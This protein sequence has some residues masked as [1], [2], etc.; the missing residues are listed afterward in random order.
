MPLPSVGTTAGKCSCYV[1]NLHA[2]RVVSIAVI[3]A[4]INEEYYG[5]VQVHARMDEAELHLKERIPNKF[6]DHR[7]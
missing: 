7:N 4:Y 3:R 6:P 1:A 2:A 5:N